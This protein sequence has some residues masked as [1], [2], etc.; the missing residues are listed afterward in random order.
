MNIYKVIIFNSLHVS[1]TNRVFSVMFLYSFASQTL[2]LKAVVSSSSDSC[3]Q[4][5]LSVTLLVIYVSFIDK[6]QT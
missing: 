4:K 6:F 3:R 5:T 1:S 2:K